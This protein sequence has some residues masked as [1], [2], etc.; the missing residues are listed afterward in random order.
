MDTE[1]PPDLLERLNAHR[2]IGSAPR[3]ELEWLVAHGHYRKYDTDYVIS[4]KADGR[5]EGM[6]IVLSGHASIS[7]DRGGARRKAIEWRAGD[8]MGTLPYSRM[9]IPPGDSIAEEPTEVLMVHRDDFAEMIRECHEITSTLVHIMLDRARMFT[10]DRLLDEKMISLGKLAAGLAHELNNPASAVA[11]SAK[12]LTT[13]LM[14]T[15]TAARSLGAMNLSEP[16][17]TVL[18]ATRDSCL[19]IPVMSIRSPLEQ[20]E[21]EEAISDWLEDHSADTAL[22]DQLAE[23]SVTIEGLDRLGE[24]FDGARLDA[25]LRWIATGCSTRVLAMEI[26]RGANRIFDL[27]SAIKGFTYMDQATT[28]QPV[29][30]RQGLLN[31]LAVVQSKA[32]SK[33]VSIVVKVDEDLPM[34]EGF[35]GELNQVWANLLDNAIDAVPE[36]GRI[37][38]TAT[39]EGHSLVVSVIDNGPGVPE[40]IQARIF[41]PFFT[42]KP[43]GSGTG[44]GLDISRRLVN[45]SKGE[46]RLDSRPGHTRFSVALPISEIK[47]STEER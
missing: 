41:D 4:A 46:L 44:L 23:T 32:K 43:V 35:G 3:R 42:T 22:S 16:E 39:R 37:E 47:Q 18:E 34:I 33:M 21:R 6:Y 28:P 2:T 5:P 40:E 26:E 17:R 19:A 25:A 38:V 29:D 24:V 10:S 14:T 45:R 8:I 15:E 30:V 9:K 31:T 7:V 13:R 27:V 12:Q 1:T 20:A 36:S 11:R